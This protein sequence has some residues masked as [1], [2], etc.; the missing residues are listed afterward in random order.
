MIDGV[1]TAGVAPDE[2]VKRVKQPRLAELVARSL[3]DDI[4]RGALKEGDRLPAFDELLE[5]FEVSA[6]V[7]REAVRILETEGLL[8]VRR[9]NVGGAVVH[10]PSSARVGY[11]ASLVLQT[12][13]VRLSDVGIALSELEPRCAALCAQTAARDSDVLAGL[14]AALAEEDAGNSNGAGADQ[15][16]GVLVDRCGNEALALAVR[17]LRAIW[18]GHGRQEVEDEPEGAIAHARIAALIAGGDKREAF[19]AEHE[20]LHVSGRYVPD[21]DVA[22]DHDRVTGQTPR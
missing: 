19:L 4:L 14:D 10:L 18:D 17:A 20:H 1:R 16:H 3:R 22:I 6:P 5:R 8:S 9:G 21:D 12:E 13:R 11:M 7:G 2:L 15:F